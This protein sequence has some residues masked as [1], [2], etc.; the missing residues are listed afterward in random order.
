[1]SSPADATKAFP[2][3]SLHRNV[4]WFMKFAIRRQLSFL[5]RRRVVQ[6]VISVGSLADILDIL[7]P[8]CR[9][10]ATEAERLASRAVALIFLISPFAVE[11]YGVDAGANLVSAAAPGNRYCVR[12]KISSSPPGATPGV[13][14]LP[15]SVPRVPT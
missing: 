9:A 8:A 15:W 6:K 10:H 1:M 13:Y 3:K 2:E 5:G 12:P 7:I 4:N 14:T 11:G